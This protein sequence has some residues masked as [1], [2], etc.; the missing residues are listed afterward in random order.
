MEKILIID[1]KENYATM[2]SEALRLKGYE[3]VMELDSGKALQAAQSQSVD[4]VI[5]DFVMS[6]LNGLDVLREIKKWDKTLPVILITDKR[7]FP[8]IIREAEKEGCLD[9]LSK[10]ASESGRLV[11]FDDLYSKVNKALQFRKILQEN[12]RLRNQFCMENVIGCSRKM[13]EVYALIQKVAPTDCTVLIHGESGTG[14]ELV[15]RA[16]HELS[17]RKDN[18]WVPINCGGMPEQLLESELFGHKRGAFTNAFSDKRGLFEEAHKGTLFLD[19]IGT[20]PLALQAKLLR[21]L[22]EHEIRRVGEN[23][24]V[25]VDVRII[26]ATNLPLQE[27][28]KKGTFREDLFYRLN[29]IPIDIPPLRERVEDIPLLV[30]H[31]IKNSHVRNSDQEIRISPEALDIL[32]H[33]HWPG[34]V[35]ELQNVIERAIVLCDG[36]TIKPV[37]LS[38]QIR[39]TNSH[40]S[41][42]HST[43][44]NNHHE[45]V[46]PPLDEIIGHVE[47]EYCTHVVNRCQG[48]KKKAAEILKISV[49]ALYRKLKAHPDEHPQVDVPVSP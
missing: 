14:K 17:P 24:T 23:T 31:C 40:A 22:Q 25:K 47:K 36:R 12:Q 4:L 44:A 34:N 1:D 30:A 2:L 15:A 18:P 32:C 26:A 8:E 19:E 20:L 37:D 6:P 33:Y 13:E 39:D 28:I 43:N 46:L 49:P 35:R 11:D 3:T 21:A 16:L 29:V 45:Q 10:A 42:S 41:A 48:D 5:S 7:Q 9:F 27:M 38:P